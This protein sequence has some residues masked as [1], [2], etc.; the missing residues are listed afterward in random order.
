LG[1]Y[2]DGIPQSVGEIQE[3][4]QAATVEGLGDFNAGIKDA[5]K[6]AG[7]LGDAVEAVGDRIIDTLLEIALQ[8]AILKPLGTAFG[9][10][11]GSLG[12]AI[13]GGSGLGDIIITAP[14]GARANGGLTRAG[15][16]LVGERGAEIV[17]LGNTSSVTP[18]HAIRS[19]NGGGRSGPT[20]HIG[21]IT[22]NDPA[23]I[24]A[25]VYQGIAEATPMMTKFSTDNT[26][27][28]LRRPSL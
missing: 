11:L 10:I 19:V 1:A 21:S 23:A 2:L 8:Q 4:L 24:R 28:K 20:V 15:S 16:Y 18:H 27:A 22:S 9:S 5:I 17:N 12:G 14:H 26:M 7:D 25:M 13:G 6:G 3:S